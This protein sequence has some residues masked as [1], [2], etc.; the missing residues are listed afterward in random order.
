MMSTNHL[1]K[2]LL[3]LPPAFSPC[4]VWIVDKRSKKWEWLWRPSV[5]KIP[6]T[7][8][9]NRSGAKTQPIYKWIERS[10]CIV[11]VAANDLGQRPGASGEEHDLP[12]LSPGSLRPDG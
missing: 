7:A 12:A 1:R 11:R 10:F 8:K 6:D 2:T 5:W 9:N 3:K 4:D